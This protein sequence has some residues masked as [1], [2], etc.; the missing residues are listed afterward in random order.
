MSIGHRARANATI[1]SASKRVHALGM[2]SLKAVLDVKKLSTIVLA[3]NS[4]SYK[5][6]GRQKMAQKQ[7]LCAKGPKSALSVM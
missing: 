1:A 3:T 4:I 5:S 7:N 2:D 6:S